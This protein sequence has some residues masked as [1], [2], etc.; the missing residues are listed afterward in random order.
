[1]LRWLLLILAV[2]FCYLAYYDLHTF[3]GGLM[4]FK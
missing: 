3:G 4:Q 1:M 2:V